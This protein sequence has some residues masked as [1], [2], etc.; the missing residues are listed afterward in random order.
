MSSLTWLASYP[1]SGNTWVRVFLE[2]YDATNDSPVDINRLSIRNAA[3]L[4]WFDRC[5]PLEPTEFTSDE[6]ATFRPGL[7]RE[8][9]RSAD[10]PLSLKVHDAWSRVPGG[11]ALFPPDVTRVVI[12]VVR[13]PLD[14]APSVSRH[15]GMSLD[16]A[17]DALCRDWSLVSATQCEQ[18]LG[19]WSH[20]VMSWLNDSGLPL[21]LLRFEDLLEDPRVE[22][23][24]VL[25]ASGRPVEGPRLERAIERSRFEALQA[26][27]RHFDFRE[28]P[29]Y[30]TGS[31]FATGTSGGWRTVL[32]DAQ[33]GRIVDAHG[34]VMRRLRYLAPL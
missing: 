23:A 29:Q 1:K 28:R 11:E 2:N 25:A 17:V 7:F 22:F 31:F 20:H 30:S 18:R 3:D 9:A 5:G 16:G 26:Q 12:Y 4:V 21:C 13:N 24:R 33:V 6:L 27:E 32:S 14:I 8:L 15:F 10:A 19:T 34:S